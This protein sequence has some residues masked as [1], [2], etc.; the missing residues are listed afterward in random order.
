MPRTLGVAAIQSKASGYDR[1][2]TVERVANLI[3]KAADMGAEYVVTIELFNR[4]FFPAQ[5][6]NSDWYGFAEPIPGYTT[7]QLGK[8]AREKQVY[9][10][11]GIYEK[12][13]VESLNFNTLA[14]IGPTGEVIGKYR[15]VHVPM[16]IPKNVTPRYEDYEKFY[17]APGDLGLPVFNTGKVK[18]GMAICYD[19]NFPE[20]WRTLVLN[21]AEVVFL[22]VSS[23]GFRKEVYQ[24][25]LRTHAYENGIF[26]V[27]P[28]RLG[29]EGP[30]HFY[31]SSVIVNPFGDIVASGDDANEQVVYAE[32]DLDEV[33]EARR[34][35][36]YFRDRRP[37]FYK[38]LVE[39]SPKNQLIYDV[40]AKP[41]KQEPVV[42]QAQM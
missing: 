5:G 20:T 29:D 30:S 27:G 19:R 25:E 36:T 10:M 42:V 6:I 32:I 38:N 9:I 11:A 8:V 34:R 15:K 41:A 16:I 3:S 37:E 40:T 13:E 7:D 12:T 18:L 39:L 2:K 35:L 31:G 28:N 33:V 26:I 23:F 17:Y 24:F 22:S 21:G 14:F 1:E 4:W